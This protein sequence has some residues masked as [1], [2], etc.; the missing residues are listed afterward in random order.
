MYAKNDR[1]IAPQTFEEE[2]HLKNMERKDLAR[3]NGIDEGDEGENNELIDT[4]PGRKV[5]WGDLPAPSLLDFSA[6]DSLMA[7]DNDADK[8]DLSSALE[9]DSSALY[10]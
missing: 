2:M 9:L 7:D 4:M 8:I 5:T 1:E 10:N 6:E 3:L